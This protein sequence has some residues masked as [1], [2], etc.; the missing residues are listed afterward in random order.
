MQSSSIWPP[1]HHEQVDLAADRPDQVR[2][3]QKLLDAEQLQ[4]ADDL[5]ED[6]ILAMEEGFH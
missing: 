1:I 6:L 5:P 3:L 2:R 4:D